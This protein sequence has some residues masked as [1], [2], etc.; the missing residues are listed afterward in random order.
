MFGIVAVFPACHKPDQT[1]A[2]GSIAIVQNTAYCRTMDSTQTLKLTTTQ[3]IWQGYRTAIPLMIGVAPFGVVFGALAVNAGL[4]IVQ[5]LG[6]S[7]IVLAGSSQFVAAGLIDSNTPIL[8]IIFTTFVINLRHFLYSAS[9]A[10]FLKPLSTGWKALLGYMMVDE[11][12]AVVIIQHRK[13]ELS[14][15]E[16]RWYFFGAGLNLITVWWLTSVI[17]AALG[18]SKFIEDST[19]VLG[20]TLP[21]IF[22]AIVVPLLTTRPMLFA[23]VV[24]AASAIVFNPMPHKLGLL[25]AAAMG[26]AAG[27]L[28]EQRKQ[29][30]MQQ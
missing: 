29:E 23:A 2:G 12:Y 26:I 24:A 9:L 14:P 5:A 4:S 16:L 25:I 15:G 8:I 22:T 21:L 1:K 13:R 11:V 6:M 30:R 7:V 28:S 10:N 27:V 20:F 17:G 3:L 18:E 19:D